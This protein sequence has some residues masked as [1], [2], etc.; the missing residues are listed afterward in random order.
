MGSVKDE[1]NS[2]G[3]TEEEKD[4]MRSGI[5]GG[6]GLSGRRIRQNRSLLEMGVEL[7]TTIFRVKKAS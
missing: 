6:A 7:W 1:K 2:R 4:G 3:G 5:V